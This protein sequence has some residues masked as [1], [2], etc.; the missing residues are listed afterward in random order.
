VSPLKI[1]RYC[2]WIR[3]TKIDLFYLRTTL[4]YGKAI[5]ERN[6]REAIGFYGATGVNVIFSALYFPF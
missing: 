4:K 6:E 3:P 1:A 5:G 2:R